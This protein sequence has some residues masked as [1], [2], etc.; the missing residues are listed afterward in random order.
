MRTGV[1]FSNIFRRCTSAYSSLSSILEPLAQRYLATVR[2]CTFAYKISPTRKCRQVGNHIFLTR[3]ITWPNIK[4]MHLQRSFVKQE[5]YK[6][7]E[8]TPEQIMLGN[9][10]LMS[11]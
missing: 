9:H 8:K 1:V 10:L 5:V 4:G 3:G 7:I 6:S 11:D 2:R